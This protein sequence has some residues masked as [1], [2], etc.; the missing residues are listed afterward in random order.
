MADQLN[1]AV[2]PAVPHR[3]LANRHIQFIAIGGAI[4]AGLFLGSGAAIAAAGPATLLAYALCGVFV[5]LMARALGELTLQASASAPFVSYVTRYVHPV[6]GFVTGW[7]YWANW[8]L[9]SAAEMTAAGLFVRY[10]FPSVPQWIVVAVVFV[11]VVFV[12]IKAVRVFGEAEFWLALGKILAVLA[13]VVLG[14]FVLFFPRVYPVAGASFGNLY[15]YGGVVPTG[16]A[17]LIRL[18]PAALFAYGGVEVVALTAREA[19]DPQ[20]TIP[21]A[22]NGVIA[23]ILVFYIGTMLVLMS[24]APWTSY[25]AQESPFVAMFVRIGIPAAGSLVNFVVLTAVVSAANT[26]LFATGRML[27]GLAQ[28]GF[29]PKS[30]EP[31]DARGV[32]VAAICASGL[33][34]MVV[35]FLNWLIPQRA[36]GVVIATTGYLLLSVWLM[37]MIAHYN[38]RS[39]LGAKRG[40]F[41]LPLFPWSTWCSVAF[42]VLMAILLVSNTQIWQSTV[43]A[44][45]WFATMT[46]VG[47]VRLRRASG[48]QRR[49]DSTETQPM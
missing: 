26:G 27:S 8:V 3:G 1:S 40:G 18:L 38:M 9:V 31:L 33:C 39:R 19:K 43:A 14:L 32:P 6:A 30:L 24:V 16:L 49:I 17:G 10:W 4:G 23:R 46:G 29:A 21:R 11:G 22:I 41:G 25:S 7:T 20:T 44:A 42:I 28:E 2:A 37:V 15:R 12:N 34:L 48:L 35:V 45:A 36:F 13:L 47:V 5:F